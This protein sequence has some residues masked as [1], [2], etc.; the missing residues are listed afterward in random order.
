M[1]LWLQRLT[2]SIRRRLQAAST[3]ELLLHCAH[4]NA[5]VPPEWDNASAVE[6]PMVHEIDLLRCLLDEDYVT[7]EVRYGVDGRTAWD[8]YACQVAAKAAS[9]SRDTQTIT[10]IRYDAIL[11]AI[12]KLITFP[13]S[14]F[15]FCAMR[16]ST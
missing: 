9:L 4:R 12:A 8:G 3:V 15:L 11:H 2:C 5:A 7:A 10:E 6:N 16:A 1:R 14:H 13:L